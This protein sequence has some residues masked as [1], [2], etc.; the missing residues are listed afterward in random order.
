MAVAAEFPDIDTLWGLR[1]PVE[2]FTHHR[3]ITH[4]FLGLPFEA[5]FVVG[6]VYALHRWRVARTAGDS[7]LAGRPPLTKAPVRWGWLYGFA[8]VA[9]LSHILLDF[10]NNYGVRPFFPFNP[11]W[12]AASIVFIFDPALFGV[13]LLALGLPSIFRLVSAEIGARQ[14]PFRGRGFAITALLLIGLYESARVVEHNRAVEI[15]SQQTV[16]APAGALSQPLV[17]GRVL[18]SP[19]PLSLFRWYTVADYG[20]VYGLGEVD[21][22]TRSFSPAQGTEAKPGGDPA[23]RAAEGSPLGRAYMDWSP[24]P[25]VSVSRP[26]NEAETGS[27]VVFRDPRFMGDVPLLHRNGH[28]PLTGTVVLDSGNRVVEERLDGSA[29]SKVTERR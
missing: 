22:Q 10:T 29:E 1:G 7:K 23:T 12:Y 5:V 19:D 17:P 9:V 28:T 27:E 16:D 2:G 15:A 6:L 3:G 25:L 21:T 18:A 14:Q 4:T 11:H 26:E 20:P 13:L 24:M 8:L